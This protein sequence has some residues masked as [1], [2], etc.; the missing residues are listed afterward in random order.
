MYFNDFAEIISD[1]PE[2]SE[3]TLI[4][5]NFPNGSEKNRDFKIRI[6]IP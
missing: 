1:F 2:K 4:T 6:R 5:G 3:Y